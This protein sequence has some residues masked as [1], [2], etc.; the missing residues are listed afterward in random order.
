MSVKVPDPQVLLDLFG[1]CDETLAKMLLVQSLGACCGKDGTSTDQAR[2]F[3]LAMIWQMAPRDAVERMLAVQMAATHAGLMSI[4]NKLNS[5]D[6]LHKHETYK[7]S[8][9]RLART[10][11]AQAEALRKH[12]NG[13]QS[14]VIVEHVTVNEGD[15]A[16]VGQVLKS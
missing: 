13:G 14:K 2:D 7:R 10:F 1:I 5:V 12:R 15:Q 6:S 9:N 11:T 3:M 8:F 4:S 16:I